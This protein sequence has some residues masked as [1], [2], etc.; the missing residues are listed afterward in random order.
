LSLCRQN[1][2]FNFASCPFAVAE[3]LMFCVNNYKIG[4]S[5]VPLSPNKCTVIILMMS[6]C[7]TPGFSST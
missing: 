2:R 3:N 5:Q 7:Q 1:F 6:T 4:E